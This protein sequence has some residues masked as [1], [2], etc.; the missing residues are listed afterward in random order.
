MYR[1]H[2]ADGIVAVGGGSGLD[3]GKCIAMAV[4]SG[5]SVPLKNFEKGRSDLWFQS[6]WKLGQTALAHLIFIA[7]HCFLY[8][9][10][11]FY[12]FYPILISPIWQ[13][14]FPE[15]PSLPR[16]S[17]PPV[18]CLPTTSGT[19]AEMDSP[20]M[21]TDSAAGVKRC[22]EHPHLSIGGKLQAILGRNN[23]KK[24]L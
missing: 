11:R 15:T 17:F 18:V 13:A 9:Y 21:F 6:Q 4:A 3:A 10:S 16:A 20:S 14:F 24:M 22:A 7:V 1:E 8:L 2:D 5:G 19:G 12:S 23:S